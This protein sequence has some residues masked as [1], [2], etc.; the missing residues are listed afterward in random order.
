[1]LTR[2]LSAALLAGLALAP[3]ARAGG[4]PQ[5][6]LATAQADGNY[7]ILVAAL[8]ATGL[9]AALAGPGPLTVF[10]PTDA[11]FQAL[12]QATIDA[13]L[14]D[15]PTLASILLHHVVPG[16]LGSAE[17]AAA[18]T[19]TTLFDQRLDVTVVGPSVLLDQ[20]TVVQ[21]DVLCSNGV[22]HGI[23][24]VLSPELGTVVDVAVADGSFTSLVAALQ[25]TGLDQTL[26]GAGPFTVFA[27]ADSAFAQLPPATL[28]RL[29]AP[30]G[31]PLLSTILQVH[32]VPG[33]L[34]ADQVV[35]AS[36]LVTVNGARL[37]V[38]VVNGEVFVAGSRIVATDV[39]ARNGTIHVVERV[40]GATRVL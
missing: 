4:T 16:S 33:R 8:Q 28:A 6:L 9:D 29:L 39:E 25:A 23:D 26:A 3:A 7:T 35:A 37:P 10:A 13:L 1:M 21:P 32:V 22:L 2:T 36:E 24:A 5:D 34:Y 11:A 15:P 38:N 30:Q 12:G 14:N 19:L 27:P 18:A 17:V 20:A 31:Q 40:I